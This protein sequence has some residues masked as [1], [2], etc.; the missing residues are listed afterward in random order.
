MCLKNHGAILKLHIAIAGGWFW[1]CNF[2][3]SNIHTYTRTHWYKKP[4]ARQK[5]KIT[6]SIWLVITVSN[7][8]PYVISMICSSVHI[9]LVVVVVVVPVH[10]HFIFF[11]LILSILLITIYLLPSNTLFDVVHTKCFVVGFIF[12]ENKSAFDREWKQKKIK[13]KNQQEI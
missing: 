12:M 5:K 10:F 3:G 7:L 13:K 9:Q 11:L 4:N 1:R 8:K 6:T 2:F